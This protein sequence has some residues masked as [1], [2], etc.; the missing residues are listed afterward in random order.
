MRTRRALVYAAVAAFLLGHVIPFGGLV[1]YPFTLLTTWVHET[2]HGLA[3]LAVGGHF[4]RLDIFWDASGQAFT[5]EGPRWPQAIVAL[6]GLLAPPIVGA[7]LFVFVRGGR[8]ALGA[9]LAIAAGLLVTLVLWVRSPVGL[10]VVPLDA[11]AI[12]F[13]AWRSSPERRMVFAH[14]LAVVLALDTLGRM[15]HYVFQKT[16]SVGGEVS[17][18][19]VA[20]IADAV[21]GHYVLWGLAISAFAMGLLALSVFVAWREP[22]AA[23]AAQTK[24]AAPTRKS[25]R[26][27]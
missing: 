23:R 24:K 5:S 12:A 21:G 7:A 20:R 3:A 9:L 14:F 1:M 19:D 16:A 25:A 27:P 6:G 26:S 8:R 22:A 15:V 4:T 11:A 10:V 18:S 13:V 17:K 2:G